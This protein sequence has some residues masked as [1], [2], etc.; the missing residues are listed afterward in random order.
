[1]ELLIT[2]VWQ[3]F[4]FSDSLLQNIGTATIEAARESGVEVGLRLARKDILSSV[5]WG[6]DTIYLRIASTSS[7][8]LG[9]IRLI[10]ITEDNIVIPSL[11]S[12]WQDTN[13]WNDNTA[14]S[15]V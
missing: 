10:P 13:I 6:Q 5:L 15:D 9:Q 2:S 7:S 14:W 1:M 3:Q 8:N 4:Q 11:A 12:V